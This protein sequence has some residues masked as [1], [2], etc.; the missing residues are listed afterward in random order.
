MNLMKKFNDAK[1]AIYDHVGFKEDW[2]IYPI[3]DN[4][5]MFW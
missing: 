2:V 1:Q 5:E 3:D 4:T